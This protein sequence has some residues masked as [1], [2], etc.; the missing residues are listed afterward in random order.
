MKFSLLSEKA[1]SFSFDCTDLLSNL[2]VDRAV[3]K[4]ISDSRRAEYFLSV[5]AKPL[6]D[7]DNIKYR[8]EIFTDLHTIPSLFEELRTVFTRYDKIRQDWH[9]LRLSATPMSD[10]SINPEALLEHTF[11]SLKVTAIFPGT[12]ASYYGSISEVLS[13]YPIKSRGLCSM[14]DYCRD[15]MQNDSL[16]EFVEIAQ[17]FKYHSPEHFNFEI[18]TLFDSTLRLAGCGLSDISEFKESGSKFSLAG[19]FKKK[20][21]DDGTVNVATMNEEEAAKDKKD[22]TPPQLDDI[23]FD[24]SIYLQNE[25]LS[26]ID[27]V[28]TKVTND[29]YETFFGMSRELMFYEA[30]LIYAR[31]AEAEEI[32]LSIPEILPPEDDLIE[33]TGLRELYLMCSG[34]EGK[35]IVPNDVIMKKDRCGMLIKGMTDTGKT[36]YLRSI[37][38]AQLFAQ[39]G[40]PVLAESARFSIRHGF[41]SH[42]SS[43]EEEFM[44]GDA[45]GRFDQEAKEVSKIL[46]RIVPHSL[47]FFNETFQTTSYGEGTDGMANILRIL[48]KLKT[49]Y[50]FVTHLTRLFDVMENDGAI[51]ASTAEGEDQ[52][53]KII[54]K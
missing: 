34:V 51:L 19:L 16:N 3:S 43:A 10:S 26:R 48:P 24:D 15:M 12:I 22:K 47:V 7:I 28:M 42:F 5:L 32:P 35:K 54:A 21:T 9:E 46:D 38:A 39:A 20:Q 6:S 37:G 31:K 41:F 4:I 50:I 53:Y 11:A 40:L 13:R 14:R 8:Q 45:A 2:S 44:A 23:S 30:A 52:K 1:E 18:S 29:V 27:A 25:A 17:L 33:V 36:V 49:K